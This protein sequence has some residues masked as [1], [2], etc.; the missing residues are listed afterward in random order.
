MNDPVNFVDLWGLEVWNNLKEKTTE[1]MKY[2]ADSLQQGY[3]QITYFHFEGRDEKNIIS[4]S[5]EEIN[6]SAKNNGIWTLLPEEMSIYHQNGIGDLELKYIC[7]NGREAVFTRDFSE[8]GSYQLYTDPQYIETY[9][10]C[11]PLNLPSD[12]TDFEGIFEFA[13]NGVATFFLICFYII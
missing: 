5:Y 1:G 9:N 12:I 10:Y 11:N 2:I 7:I 4:E 3:E 13:V 8:D 6:D